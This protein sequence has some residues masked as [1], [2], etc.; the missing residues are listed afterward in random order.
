MVTES[1]WPWKGNKN[2]LAIPGLGE[3]DIALK[4]IKAAFS[5]KPEDLILFSAFNDLWKPLEAKTFFVERYWGI[6]GASSV[7]GS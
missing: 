6:S 5:S 7:P 3:Q 2:G 4:S 1:G